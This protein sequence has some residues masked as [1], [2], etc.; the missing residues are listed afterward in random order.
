MHTIPHLLSKPRSIRVPLF[1]A[2]AAAVACSLSIGAATAAETGQKNR[3]NVGLVSGANEAPY[4]SDEALE[5]LKRY[6][7][8]AY[9]FDCIVFQS[10][11]NTGRIGGMDQLS[12]VD[13]AFL[14]V[15]P[16]ATSPGT[17]AA[18]REFVDS[19]KG[20]VAVGPTHR[21]WEN[22]PSFD[23]EVLGSSSQG[24]TPDEHPI[25]E[26]RMRLHPILTGG[27]NFRT[28]RPVHPYEDFASG[29]QVIVEG[30]HDDD[31]FFP[32]AWTRERNGTRIVYL[33]PGQKEEFEKTAYLRILAN[34]LLWAARREIPGAGLQ[35]QRTWMPDVHP[36]SF[37]VGFPC[38][39]NFCFDPVTN[40]VVYAWDGDYVDRWPTV[41]GKFPRNAKV[42][43]RIF[44]THTEGNG[45]QSEPRA[46]DGANRFL[47]YRLVEGTP[48]FSYEVDGIRVRERIVPRDD[49]SAL[50]RHVNVE[51][52]D[53]PFY[54]RPDD[55]EQVT[56]LSGDGAWTDG[57]LR[58]PAQS[59]AAFTVL[60][61]R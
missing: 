51:G 35:L 17:E 16:Q 28:D 61:P 30:R 9:S 24:D 26:I 29:V 58:F 59:E 15:H 10:D 53:A 40:L 5:T 20:L 60:I 4:H 14:L 47:G 34:S 18:L 37:A 32:I 46:S 38:G 45:F 12:R 43:G 13:V 7:E 31:D 39:L 55:P 54:F 33:A 36:S 42:Q 6:L 21:A 49:R 27:E 52:G 41:S 25:S 22:W 57:R 3:L 48:E 11:P 56:L 50:V 2:L 44:F 19:G 23:V 8:T 1:A